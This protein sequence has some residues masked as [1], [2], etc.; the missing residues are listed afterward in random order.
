MTRPFNGLK[1]VLKSGALKTGGNLAIISGIVALIGLCLISRYNYLLFHVL[2]ELFSIVIG[3]TLFIVAWNLRR[4]ITNHYILF[5]GI[6][7]LFVAVLDTFH[8]LSYKGM[9]VFAIDSANAAT[10]L[11]IAARF[12]QGVSLL[13]APYFL[14]RKLNSEAAFFLFTVFTAIIL[15][16][17]YLWNLFPACYIE[18][19]GLTPFKITGEYI[20]SSILLIALIFLYK[21]RSHFDA[22]VLRWIGVS[23]VATIVSELA[24]T[25]YVGVYDI[26]NLIGHF[27]KII[28]F[29][30]IY[31]AV[32]K[33]AFIKP[34]DL[35]FRDLLLQRTALQEEKKRAQNYLDMAGIIVVLNIDQTIALINKSGCRLLGYE[36]REVIG[37]NWFDTFLPES[38]RNE[39][40]AVFSKLITGTLEGT[41]VYEN[42]TLSVSGEERLIRWQNSLLRDE[43]G[44]IT[45]TLNAGED[46]TEWKKAEAEKTNLAT[47]PQLNPNP[48]VEVDLSGNV[49]FLNPAAERLFPDLRRL[50]P[51]HPWLKDW[52]KWVGGFLNDRDQEGWREIEV[53]GEWYNQTVYFVDQIERIRIYGLHITTRKRAE[54]TLLKIHEELEQRVRERTSQLDT[55]N[56]HLTNEIE[57][58]KKAQENLAEQ[59]RL[60]EAFFKHSLTPIVFL[61]K[62]FNFIKVNDAYAR[63]CQREA[64]AFP[65]HNHFEFYPSDA[66]EIF[67]QVVDTKKG[68]QTFARPFTFPDHPEWG[69]TYWDWTLVPILDDT[70]EIDFLVYSLNDVTIRKLAVEEVQKHA[71]LLDL[72]NDTIMVC[73][74]DGNIIYWNKG[75]EHLYGWSR[76]EAIGQNIQDLLQPEFGKQ[77]E[78]AKEVFFR[79]GYWEGEIIHT[80]KDGAKVI[81]LS[82]WT[83][84][85][86]DGNVPVAF[87]EINRDITELKRKEKEL[88]DSSLYSRSLI[89]ASLDP[90]VTINAEG[91]IMDVSRATEIATGIP[92]QQLIGSD[93]SDYFTDPQKAREGYQT[94]FSQ[95][96]VRDYPLE[97][98]HVSGQTTEVLYNATDYRDEAGNVQGVFAAA[99]DIT[100]L[101]TVQRALQ[102]SHDELERRVEERTAELEAANED[103]ESFSYSVS[104]DLQGPLRAIDGYARMILRDHADQFDEDTKQK[105]GTI[106][107]NAQMMGQLINDLLA[108]SRLGRKEIM[109]SKL[110]MGGLLN[111]A[112]KELQMIHLE[113]K[114]ILDAQKMPPAFGDR[115]LIKQV[116]LNLLSNAIKFTKYRE[117]AKI[118]AG[119]YADGK[120]VVY[121]IIDNGVG[122]D[123]T[124]HDKMFGVFQRLHSSEEFEGTGVGLAI[125]QRIIHRH[126]GRV[127]AEG[128]PDR[129][130]SFY[131][132]LKRKE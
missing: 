15:G 8:T 12:L 130:A 38:I 6:A 5:I 34:Y 120:Q 24:F 53:G 3:V 113:R 41:D 33:T 127:W 73:N 64:S 125:V 22:E 108:F 28:A 105:F 80:K 44:R 49:H 30:L 67:R 77:L 128:R 14:K 50:G 56:K 83:L 27:F 75:A 48:V 23:I 58:K 74:L 52:E 84:Q 32:I 99:R 112:W 104:H 40:K 18:G 7:Y 61:D 20:I 10:Q 2:V 87:S 89:E 54:E 17:I 37:K 76:S 118:E 85:R 21:N 114:M 45:G 93:F 98:R 70:R 60:L 106:R 102:K 121:Y 43:Q 116:L 92:R 97:I 109:P 129:G 66:E 107:S 36:E 31:K 11:W 110:D 35:L 122:F 88:R 124:Y 13:A 96:F 131:F 79:D 119:G 57:E 16:S 90:L 100:E 42:P 46:I 25:F 111:D 69:I 94:A 68:Y 65:G 63:V 103:L 26:S 71:Q 91:K 123:M 86:N 117:C 59:S 4:T 101:R 82:R 62:S 9:G 19:S 132:S 72:A 78:G 115:T 47:F 1:S 95:S 126:G 81:V 51:A 39:A 29:Y 55:A